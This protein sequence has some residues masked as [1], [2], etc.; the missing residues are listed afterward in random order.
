MHPLLILVLIFD[1]LIAVSSLL[2]LVN[3][4]RV[5]L[6]LEERQS[7]AF[8]VQLVRVQKTA[9]VNSPL[10]TPMAA[11]RLCRRPPPWCP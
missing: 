8:P 7:E 1:V 11:S 2:N 4:M 10:L 5:N 9:P 6:L 3:M